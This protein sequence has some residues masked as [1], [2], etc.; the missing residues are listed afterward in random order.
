M[1]VE[2]SDE[3]A[4]HSPSSQHT[5]PGHFHG[6]FAGDEQHLVGANGNY[7]QTLLYVHQEE[8]QQRLMEMYGSKMSLID[9]TYKTTRYDLA[10]FFIAVRTNVGY[11]IVAEFVT[12]SETASEIGEALALLKQWNPRWNPNYF[13]SD[14]SDAELGAIE[15]TFPHCKVYLYLCDFH[16]EQAWER[17]VRERKH[18]L[19]VSDGDVLLSLLRNCAWAPPARN[20]EV[21]PDHNYREAENILKGSAVWRENQAV[22]EWLN[23]KWLSIPEVYLCM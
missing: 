19:S 22:Q 13:L 14:Y 23:A 12:Q 2:E 11:I 15:Q 21:Q 5:L 8:W 20:G 9:A 1:K 18:G 10:L 3:T 6:N 7:S 4:S 17:W 16:R